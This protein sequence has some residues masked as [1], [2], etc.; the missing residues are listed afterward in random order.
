LGDLDELPAIPAPPRVSVHPIVRAAHHDAG[1]PLAAAVA[2]W[3]CE[4]MPDEPSPERV[5]SIWAGA[6]ITDGV[7]TLGTRLERL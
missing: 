3:V 7:P 2:S 6:A 4:W 1:E 5:I